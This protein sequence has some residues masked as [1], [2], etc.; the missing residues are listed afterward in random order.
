MVQCRNDP[1]VMIHRIYTRCVYMPHDAGFGSSMHYTTFIAIIVISIE[2]LLHMVL[3][4]V[5]IRYVDLVLCIVLLL[6][7]VLF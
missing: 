7:M 6:C 1:S 4:L 3:F 5:L 2:Y